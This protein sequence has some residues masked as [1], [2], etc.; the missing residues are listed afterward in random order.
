[1]TYMMTFTTPLGP[2]T[3]TSDGEAISSLHFGA[4]GND[5]PC[6]LLEKAAEQL[7]EYF[8]GRRREFDLPLKPEGTKFQQAVWRALCDIPYGETRSYLDIAEA[9][10]NKKACRAVGLANGR[11]PVAVVIPCHRVIGTDGSLTGY[12]SGVD[13]KAFLLALENAL[14]SGAKRQ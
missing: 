7:Q 4:G 3:L 11:N 2:M 10:G 14:P 12:A 8:D 5:N 1:M 6:P 13:K 9:L